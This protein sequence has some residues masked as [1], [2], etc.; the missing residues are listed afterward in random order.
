MGPTGADGPTGAAGAGGAVGPT[1]PSGA[2]GATG[3]TGATGSSGVISATSAAASAISPTAAGACC[4]AGPFPLAGAI[5]FVSQTV[6]VTPAA[7]EQVY[8]TAST[9]LGP[10]F[11]SGNY[12]MQFFTCYQDVQN[13]LAPGPIKAFVDEESPQTDGT[14][15][16]TAEGLYEFTRSGLTEA[17]ASSGSEIVSGNKYNFGLCGIETCLA[18]GGGQWTNTYNS[19]VGSSKTTAILIGP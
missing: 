16:M 10:N 3:A 7:G 6:S 1:G 5:G 8:V 12:V 17:A 19:T 11:T 2:G 9:E 15:T 4:C 13:P 14:V 18:S